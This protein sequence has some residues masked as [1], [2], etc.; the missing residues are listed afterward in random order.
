MGTSTLPLAALPSSLDGGG[1]VW[2]LIKLERLRL[3]EGEAS[4]ALDRLRFNGTGSGS[5]GAGVGTTTA[6]AI[7]SNSEEEAL[8]GRVSRS[9]GRLSCA[10][11]SAMRWSS[12]DRLSA[13]ICVIAGS[14]MVGFSSGSGCSCLAFCSSAAAA[15]AWLAA[16]FPD[17]GLTCMALFPAILRA[18]KLY[19]LVLLAA[20]IPPEPFGGPLGSA[21]R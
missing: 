11:T 20:A 15:A 9:A 5:T 13:T 17:L 4:E 2:M 19:C 8:A 16:V 21:G 6:V 10:I 14:L 1:A 12:R 18:P 7:G 3:T